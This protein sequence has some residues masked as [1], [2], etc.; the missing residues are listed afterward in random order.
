MTAAVPAPRF[1]RPS[2]PAMAWRQL[3]R[4]WRAGELRLLV[5]AVTLAVAALCA[6]GFLADRLDRGLARDAAQLLGGDA[7][8]ASDQPLP[9]TVQALASTLKLQSTRT[10]SFP[11]MARAPD[12]KG[13]ASRLV[14]VKAVGSDYPLRGQI[15]LSQ[16]AGGTAQLLKSAPARGTAW[17]DAEVLDKLGLQVGDALMLGE[18]SLTLSHI[19]VNEPDRGA[20]FLNFAPRVMLNEADLPA[21]GLI[22]PASR[23]TYRL[24]VAGALNG[25]PAINTFVQRAQELIKQEGLR[26]R[27]RRI[28]GERPPPRCARRWTGPASS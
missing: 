10:A 27:A 9:E 1:S 28:A 19:I 13:G 26:G 11:S 14:S 3:W 21:T 12:A 25:R 6:V 8:V 4:D 23:V 18:L 15:T 17:A 22:Q 20:G 24:A 16:S 5:L 2:V 7:V